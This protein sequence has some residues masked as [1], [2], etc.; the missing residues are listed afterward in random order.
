ML[1]LIT[2][3]P[4]SGKTLSIIDL[5]SK[6]TD[7]K[8]FYS[9]ISDLKLDWTLID[10]VKDY[11]NQLPDGAIYVLDECQKHFPVRAPKDKVPDAISFI[12][13]HRHRGID[14]YFITQHPSL[15]DHHARRLVGHHTH[16]QR[17][18]GLPFSVKYTN[19]KLFDATNYHELQTCEQTQYK[20]PKSVFNLYKS[21]E[22]HTHKFKFPKKLLIIIPL[23]LLVCYGVYFIYDLLNKHDI[24][25]LPSQHGIADLNSSVGNTGALIDSDKKQSINWTTAYI[26]ALP[27]VPFTAP[28]YKELAVPTVMPLVSGCV[29]S[30]AK[31]KCACYTQQATII[32]MSKEQ[33]ML[34]VK[35]KSFNPFKPNNPHNGDIQTAKPAQLPAL[36]APATSNSFL[37]PNAL[38]P[39]S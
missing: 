37:Q 2:G 18:F 33:C 31:D 34:N 10:D 13:T 5:L 6:V 1:Y 35:L 22:V 36:P 8:I 7:R 28:I 23:L 9:G 39:N 27:G 29:Y 30:K 26:P 12:E 32:D 3:T 15:L 14:L 25:I 11:H 4:G 21:A 38:L 20:Y 17:N 24:P 16:L 19:N